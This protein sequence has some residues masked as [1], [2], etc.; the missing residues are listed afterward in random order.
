MAVA[1]SGL[2]VMG[3]WFSLTGFDWENFSVLEERG[4]CLWEVV[5][6]EKWS[7][8]ERDCKLIEN[9]GVKIRARK[10][11][12]LWRC[13]KMCKTTALQRINHELITGEG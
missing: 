13:T 6:Y 12:L 7:H 8:I 9:S 4:G 11:V 2:W 5:A 3:S 1:R 10:K